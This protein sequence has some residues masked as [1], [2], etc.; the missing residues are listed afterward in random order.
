MLAAAGQG[1]AAFSSS[2]PRSLG[3]FG[4]GGG[5]GS[6]PTGALYRSGERGMG[7]G[8]FAMWADAG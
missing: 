2:L 3:G 6:L 5:A 4:G 7:V 1:A 8:G